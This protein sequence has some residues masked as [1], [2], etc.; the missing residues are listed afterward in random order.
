MIFCSL[1]I[2]V[3]FLVRRPMFVVL[4]VTYYI[5]GLPHLVRNNPLLCLFES[6]NSSFIVRL[7]WVGQTIKTPRKFKDLAPEIKLCGCCKY[8]FLWCEFSPAIS[9]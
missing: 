9:L 2:V 7:E 3:V 8:G 1:A 4:I 5:Q 6:L